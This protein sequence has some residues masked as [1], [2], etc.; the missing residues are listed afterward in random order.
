M[1]P[2]PLPPT[3]SQPTALSPPEWGSA[4]AKVLSSG[5]MRL[6]LWASHISPKCH[7]L[8]EVPRHHSVQTKSPA[9]N[10]FSRVSFP[11][12]LV[13]LARVSFLGLFI[14]SALP[15]SGR[16]PSKGGDLVYL[17]PWSPRP[18]TPNPGALTHG[19]WQMN[20]RT[21]KRVNE[22]TNKSSKISSI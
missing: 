4:P 8:G 14:L 2:S 9:L 3:T 21:N 12:W 18:R 20:K 7:P 16:K 11:A 17:N 22:Q 1:E 13:L 19:G 10:P 5:P 15:P 6:V